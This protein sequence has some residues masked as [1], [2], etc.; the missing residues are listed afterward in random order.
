M[1]RRLLSYPTIG[2]RIHAISTTPQAAWTTLRFMVLRLARTCCGEPTTTKWH[3]EVPR[4]MVSGSPWPHLPQQQHFWAN[5][6]RPSDGLK[7]RG[8]MF[9]LSHSA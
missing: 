9:G 8:E 5:K 7:G 2:R 6:T 1:R 3:E 4:A